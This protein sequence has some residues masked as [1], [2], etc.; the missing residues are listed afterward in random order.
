MLDK[1]P[2]ITLALSGGAARGIAFI[3]VFDALNEAGIRI[4]AIA[5]TS[6]G[7][8]A[9][10][11]YL[12]DG[13]RT[14]RLRELAARTGWGTIFRPGFS[15]MGLIDSGG[16]GALLLRELRA[17]E[18]SELPMPFAAVCS[19]A[20]TGEE[21]VITEGRLAPAIQASCSLPVIFTPTELNGRMLIDGGYTSLV[22]V[23]AAREISG[24]RVVVAVDVNHGYRK[25]VKK[26]TNIFNLAAH[27]AILT[28]R[29]MMA[30]DMARADVRIRVSAAEIGLFDFSKRDEFIKRGREAAKAAVGEIMAAMAARP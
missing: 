19:D 15:T 10:A 16:I 9:G 24:G 3:G 26:P 21:V 1:P 28:A 12:D 7:A 27:L 2:S 11:L 17:G 30:E 25:A 5:G 8:I 20:V 4:D 22:P 29:R 13:C 14:G 6:A 23:R 18:F